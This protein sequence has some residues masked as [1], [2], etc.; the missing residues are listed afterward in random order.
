MKMLL[1]EVPYNH[2]L[3]LPLELAT[4]LN[5][6]TLVEKKDWPK[7]EIRNAKPEEHLETR[8]IDDNEILPHERPPA[9]EPQIPDKATPVEVSMQTEVG[10]S[11]AAVVVPPASDD[12][13]QF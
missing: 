12:E 11:E 6:I 7:F 10:A 2:A 4:A 13:I 3:V 8:L 1:V 5:T 9:P